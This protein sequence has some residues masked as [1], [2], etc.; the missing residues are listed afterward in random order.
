MGRQS[1][2]EWR[3]TTTAGWV[4]GLIA[5]LIVWLVCLGGLMVAAHYVGGH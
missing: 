1:R 4:V 3:L 2:P 5:S